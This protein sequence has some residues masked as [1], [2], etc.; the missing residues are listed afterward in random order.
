MAAYT[1]KNLI[2]KKLFII[3]LLLPFLSKAQT[4]TTIDSIIQAKIDASQRITTFKVNQVSIIQTGKY[5]YSGDIIGLATLQ[6]NDTNLAA[7][8]VTANNTITALMA[9][10]AVLEAK[11]TDTTL[12]ARITL[13]EAKIAAGLTVTGVAK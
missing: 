11:P 2:M 4:I 5:T 8:L 10:V 13:L 12:S 6:T 3:L 1:G 9:R 7:Q